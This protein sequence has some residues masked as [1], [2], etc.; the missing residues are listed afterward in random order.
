MSMMQVEKKALDKALKI[1]DAIG[2]RYG[3]ETEDGEAFGVELV[4]ERKRGKVYNKG[5]MN[6]CQQEIQNLNV[7]EKLTVQVKD[8][9]VPVVQ[10]CLA[11]AANKLFGPGSVVTTRNAASGCIEVMRFS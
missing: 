2:C 4:R 1:L 10:S 9:D 6:Y 5:C 3:V 11:T 8:Y 7:G